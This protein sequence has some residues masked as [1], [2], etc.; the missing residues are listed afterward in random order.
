MKTDQNSNMQGTLNKRIS[1]KKRR[2]AKRA[3]LALNLVAV[4]FTTT[5]FSNPVSVLSE[6]VSTDTVQSI[7]NSP[8]TDAQIAEQADVQQ[9]TAE[10]AQAVE[11]PAAEAPAAENSAE[12]AKAEEPSG[13]NAPAENAM[14]AEM[15]AAEDG[16]VST[17]DGASSASAVQSAD[18]SS[19]S[20][21]SFEDAGAGNT[22]G[23]KDGI[24]EN[25][26]EGLNEAEGTAA[27][28]ESEDAASQEQLTYEDEHVK[29]SV[30]YT[31]GRAFTADSILTRTYLDSDEKNAVL[32]AVNAQIS[33]G[34][35]A[36]TVSDTAEN[37]ESSGSA[38]VASTTA[39]TVE[40]SVAGFHA[41]M[42]AAKNQDGSDTTTEGD[43]T[44]SAEFKKGLNDAG[45]ASREE[46]TENNE[47]GGDGSLTTTTTRCETSWKIYT[48]TEKNLTDITDITDA[49]NTHYEM[50]EN[51]TLKSASFRGA[52]PQTV[53]FVQ[54][55]KKTVTETTTQKETE[56]ATE[57]E[58]QKVTEKYTEKITGK[59]AEK[60]TE[61][62]TEKE[63]VKA[64]VP[65]SAA[66]PAVAFDQKVTTENGTV[67]V[68]IDAEEGA[69]E[70]GTSMTVTPVT[71]HDILDKAIDAAGGKGAAAAMDITFTKADGTKT[72]PLKPIHVKMISPVLNHAEE[73]HVVHVADSGTIDVV[74]RKSDG[75][76]I[77][78]TSSEAASSDAKNAVSF[79]SDSFSVYAI[80]YTVDFEYEG[81]VLH[82]PGEG[83]Y[84]LSDV[85]SELGIEGTI[86]SAE[87]K[88][89]EGEDHE[90]ALYLEEE[91]GEYWICSDIAFTDTYELD[92]KVDNVIY[93]ITVKDVSYS[94]QDA[95]S[96]VSADGF[97][98]NTWTVKEGEEYTLHITFAETPSVVQFPTTGN[99]LTYQLPNNFKPN[100]SLVD[101]PVTLSYTEASVTHTITGCT[102]SV[103]ESGQV[104]ITLTDFAKEKLAESG[105]GKFSIELSGG[106]TQSSEETNFGGGNIKNVFV[107]DKKDVTVNKSGQYNSDDNKVHYTVTVKADGSLTG[108]NVKDTI[109]GTALTMDRG[110]LTYEG[111]SSAP[112]GGPNDS[113]FD[114]TFPTMKHGET[115]TI[116]YTAS[117]NWGVIGEGKG[118]IE[119]TGNTVRVK[120]NETDEKEIENN[121]AN[122]IS[123]NP[124][125]KSAGET[126][127]SA[128]PDTKIKPWTITINAQGLKN[129]KNTV[130]TDHNDSSSVMHYAGYGISIQKYRVNSDGTKTPDGNPRD[131]SWN[132]LEIDPETA[133]TW[134]YKITEDGNYMYVISYITEVN[135]KGKNGDTYVSNHVD[136][137][138]GDGSYSGGNVGP[139]SAKIGVDK[140]FGTATREDMTWTV[141]MDIP[142]TGLSKAIMV[143]TL[144]SS[145]SY[146]DTL[147][148]ES[149]KVTGLEMGDSYELTQSRGKF[150]LTFYKDENH[151]TPGLNATGKARH[152]IVTFKTDN[153]PL[154]ITDANK[155]E[156]NHTNNV[157]FQG[158]NATV[159]DND[160]GKVPQTGIEKKSN[161]YK[162]VTINGQEKI[163]FLYE[164]DLTGVSDA[165]FEGGKNLEFTDD[166]DETY[167][168]FLDVSNTESIDGLDVYG[169]QRFWNLYGGESSQNRIVPT[170]NNGVLTF[171]VGKN[172]LPKNGQEY[173]KGYKLIYYLVAKDSTKLLNDSLAQSDRTVTISNKVK[174]G[175]FKDDVDV[176]YG[177]PALVKDN[178]APSTASD[179][180]TTYDSETGKTGFRIVINPEKLELNNGNTMT[181]EDVFSGNLSVDYSSI[182][183]VTDPAD[184]KVTY[185]YKGNK[186]IYQIPDKCKVT[187]TYDARVI[188]EPGQWVTYGNEVHMNGFSDDAG[189]RAWMGGSAEGSFNIYS[190]E[191]YKYSAG[192]MEVGL[193]GATFTLVNE[194]GDPIVYPDEATNEKA[195]DPI[196]FTTHTKD[197]K[198]GYVTISLNEQVD[199]MSLQKGI[200]YYLKETTSPNT[201][202][203]NNTIYRFTISDN[204]NY[205]NYEYHSG[206]IVKV[207]DWPVM[208]KIE[209]NKEIEGPSNLTEEDKKKITFEITG[210]YDDGTAIKVDEDGY[211]IEKVDLAKYTEEE[212]AELK[213]FKVNISYA[214][215]TDGKYVMADLVDGIYTVKETAAALP[216]Y[217]DV[218]TVSTTYEVDDDGQR[219]GDEQQSG[220]EAT[221]TITDHSKYVMNYKN[222]Y[223]NKTGGYDLI[224]KKVDKNNQ[225]KTLYGAVF[226]LE[227]MV[228]GEYQLVTEGSVDE[229]GNFSIP[230]AN[231]DTGVTL[232][233][234][235]PGQYRIT[236]IQA[237]TNYKATGDGTVEFIIN[238]D[239]TASTH[240]GDNPMIHSFVPD[241]TDQNVVGTLS[242]GNETKHSYTV[243]KVDG[244][245]VS[246]KL[247]GAEFGVWE[248]NYPA[249]RDIETAMK[250]DEEEESAP[251]W[252]YTTDENGKFEIMMGDH[253]Y[254]EGKIY[255]FK[256]TKAP[257]G[258]ELPSKTAVNYFF[259]SYPEVPPT[260][261]KPA[262]LGSASRSQTI[263][264]DLPNLEVT[265]LWKNLKGDNL[266]KDKI[267]VDAIDFVVY[268]QVNS[269]NQDGTLTP[270]G[271]ETRFP[272][273]S[274]VYTIEYTS[275]NWT[276]VSIPNAPAMGKDEEGN[277][278][279]YTYRVEE[280][281]PEGWVSSVDFSDSGREA[282]ITN[283]PEPMEIT[284]RK[285]WDVPSF[286][287]VDKDSPLAQLNVYQKN[288]VGEWVLIPIEG[289]NVIELNK[290]NNWEKR[291]QVEK[292]KEYKIVEFK[293]APDH[294]PISKFSTTVTSG[295]VTVEGRE[296]EFDEAGEIDFTNTWNEPY[297]EIKKMWN[298]ETPD[299]RTLRVMFTVYRREIGSTNWV[300]WKSG[301]LDPEQNYI[302]KYQGDELEFESGKE[303]EFYV[304]ETKVDDSG[305][306][307]KG[308]FYTS[309][310]H[311]PEE[312]LQHYGSLTIT[313]STKYDGQLT[314][315]KK[316]K[317]SSGE[318]LG[319]EKTP[320][321]VRVILQRATAD[322][323]GCRVTVDVIVG[324]SN[325]SKSIV[326][327][328]GTQVSLS[329]KGDH[330]LS[331]W[332]NLPEGWELIN[333]W[334]APEGCKI[335]G[336]TVTSDKTFNFNATGNSPTIEIDMGSGYPAPEIGQRSDFTDVEGTEV[337]LTKPNW[338]HTWENLETEADGGK[339]YVYNVRE[340]SVN[341]KTPEKAGFIS[342]VDPVDG[343]NNGT[344]TL[345]N[346][347][348]AK[349][350]LKIT[351]E[352]TIGGQQPEGSTKAD[353]TYTFRV[354]DSAGTKHLITVTI[355]G[356]VAKAEFLND[357]PEGEATVEEISST[358]ENVKIDLNP[359]V[360]NIIGNTTAESANVA[361]VT[362]TND[363]DATGSVP[364]K[365]KK[366]F[367]DE[368]LKANEFEFKLTEYTDSTFA[369]VKSEGVSQTK[370]N[371][372]EGDVLFDDISYTISDAGVDAEHPN[373]FYYTIKET[374]GTNPDIVYDETVY[375]Y[376]VSVYDNGDGTLTVSK[377]VDPTLPDG[378]PEGYDALFTN[379]KVVKTTFEFKK[380]W[381]SSNTSTE[382]MEWPDGKTI[383]VTLY[384]NATYTSDG[385]E[386]TVAEQTFGPYDIPITGIADKKIT[387]SHDAANKW[388][389]VKFDELDK[390]VPSDLLEE[391]DNDKVEWEYYIKENPL[392]GFN[393]AYGD[394][395]GTADS[396]KQI[397]KNT[398]SVINSSVSYELPESG[399]PG[400][401]LFYGLGISFVG[402]AGLLLFIK[403]RELR[404][405]SKRRW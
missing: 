299:S 25:D 93:A 281:T 77:E 36:D 133:S 208:G 301:Q 323:I 330:K 11:A 247:P 162:T 270:I 316:W 102:Y 292:G 310:S 40:Y 91:E 262:N 122:R 220:K 401:K 124:L 117:V 116:K 381:K 69:F 395:S 215:F 154:W 283:T 35:S 94:M 17:D 134:S 254:E 294:W 394:A 76:T 346:T 96:S 86:E 280:D 256:E 313:N 359:H 4:I 271:A 309:Y 365:A 150:T 343:T 300:E 168:E 303:Y 264:N 378:T 205:S 45:Y 214:D 305:K 238:D 6:E 98:G 161:G 18:T 209:L 194:N 210:T 140:E 175:D 178:I 248:S 218:A 176:D 167:L 379:Q 320:N 185:D 151:E 44:F 179:P 88:L 129:M 261:M 287:D 207:Y 173:F 311:T 389:K 197:G 373:Y 111:N 284:V 353:G 136:D 157:S 242:L 101:K 160:S 43:V 403:R 184:K 388:Y 33:K 237:P 345:T 30:S 109:G 404:D 65:A 8:G 265:K 327:P 230:Y 250:E 152:I 321:N 29:I 234:L 275:G 95:V 149:L 199:G 5:V 186:G 229:N 354:T 235:E 196:T 130:I 364:F 296:F 386:K 165:D 170:D 78:S 372:S 269:K 331:G 142:A 169:A 121:L 171:S 34:N 84:L 259:F 312:P 106:F 190:V 253:G 239:G 110:S 64:E 276:K 328:S 2:N 357:L 368:Q 233:G 392:E 249:T 195:G 290:S 348:I 155:R 200:T 118:N 20:N 204:P 314:V 315:D 166:Y 337:T 100:G 164:I 70:E 405:L 12:A 203:I 105:D 212:V 332:G 21:G 159:Y 19:A 68:H 144:P 376:T 163:V 371:N 336:L 351:K 295:T 333:Q 318:D 355:L 380:I 32:S 14:S 361:A 293:T 362:I 15:N 255:F 189:G 120:P 347:E 16:V 104:T 191:L 398:E 393:T 193:N 289:N 182:V 23:T 257:E 187:I 183:I 375:K 399:G 221:V 246:L 344:V 317:N 74:A 236:E 273:E 85:L 251:L 400:T 339:A 298:T 322:L 115:I 369:Q 341:G 211:P 226:S 52:L 227:K 306:D 325:Y 59:A 206:D 356:G 143:D 338:T 188:G 225:T 272:D 350:S 107:D 286:M 125:S 67:M 213:D 80:V 241:T 231:K 308:E 277:F 360:V 335:E 366:V 82:F 382:K 79:E 243:T 89:I 201:H 87:L 390:Y 81:R 302:K 297:L 56:K 391:P 374:K 358:N 240:S 148:V 26:A 349:G 50:D 127:D 57:K 39:T 72:E 266:N 342:V 28:E 216:G 103:N 326:V 177:Y 260:A 307:V 141:T 288:D 83:R 232:V 258:Y 49:H 139:G 396:S 222:T 147:N 370:T 42:L 291:F 27:N 252:T 99:T 112:T 223:S 274:T 146:R 3:L 73:A 278:I 219:K 198:D 385:D 180:N 228:D 383:K 387:V 51:G 244:A 31:D 145:G 384:R 38:P 377:R 61:T 92:V 66:M 46:T 324:S 60:T 41:L 267:D 263:T 22:D 282:T 131:V 97:S 397:A 224:I 268:Q 279:Y 340:I 156:E 114:L 119:Q 90:G 132:E 334:Y 113:G 181:L 202:A 9:N 319:S 245:N 367:Q 75:K 71:R 24:I 285:N 54:I 47:A 37:T 53:A 63:D 7:E 108:V 172:D 13:V 153:D 137:D 352:V 48:V 126:Q 123:Y 128:D 135:V 10:A 138:H 158:D 58:T 304:V 1:M 55:V 174:W 363:Y 192:H 62:E 217:N 329:V 402:F